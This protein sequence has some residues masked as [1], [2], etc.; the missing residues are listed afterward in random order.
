MRKNRERLFEII[1]TD[2]FLRATTAP[3]IGADGMPSPWTF[4]FKRVAV[5]GEFLRIV[6]EEFMDHYEAQYPFQVGGLEVGAVPLIAAI[7]LEA[8][9]RG[10]PV[11]SFFVRKSR[12]KTGAL[13]LI[14]GQ[15]NDQPI[16]LIDDLIHSG[17]SFLGLIE[18]FE[19][20]HAEGVYKA[21]V[22]DVFALLR[23]KAKADY[24]IFSQKN[25]HPHTL[26]DL[27]DFTAQLGVANI[28][29]T[30][31]AVD[32]PKF[33][34]LWKWQDPDPL[35]SPVVPKGELLVR[36]SHVYVG[37]DNGYFMCLSEA[38]GT[39]KWQYHI[40]LGKKEQVAFS[41]PVYCAGE[42][43]VGSRDG[44]LYALNAET[45]KRSWVYLDADW[46]QGD[47]GVAEER[48]L[49]FIPLCYGLFKRQGK[50]VALKASTGE[51]V[52]EFAVAAPLGGGISYSKQHQAIYFGTDDGQFYALEASTGR[53]LWSIE[54]KVKARGYPTVGEHEELIYFSGV[55][56]RIGDDERAYF[57]G[58]R[59]TTGAEH[60]V[61]QDFLFGSFATPALHNG[62][63]YITAIDKHLYALSSQT[64]ALL[65]KT[66]LGARSFAS[67]RILPQGT[68]D[69]L[70][71]VGANNGRL[72]FINITN[73][74]VVG[75]LYLNERIINSARYDV[76]QGI[77]IV[78]TQANEVYAFTNKTKT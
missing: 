38:A 30:A 72:N 13:N 9:R 65:W 67:P 46:I 50:V 8:E 6:G 14:E 76:G 20:L 12:K 31:P 32:T 2:V 24:Q 49:I 52:W 48:G 15:V 55:P 70:L 44:N 77:L 36:E 40:P 66:S 28:A 35:L 75:T 73:G 39:L 61:F 17:K 18:L 53:V 25:V 37:A 58:F 21:V 60:F 41:T 19:S 33:S 1:A 29:Q 63:I 69:T 78:P 68:G 45:G 51:K 5:R 71:S 23:F 43:V 10:K 34:M 57:Y 22:T 59:T 62:V 26:F 64:G 7:A 42:I 27:N 74:R 4:D 11:N 56:L 54:T 47:P 16:I 3:L